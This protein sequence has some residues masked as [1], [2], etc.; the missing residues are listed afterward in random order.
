[1]GKAVAWFKHDGVVKS[2]GELLVHAGER[3]LAGGGRLT[4]G[5]RRLSDRRFI[6]AGQG[7]GGKYEKTGKKK[8][9]VAFHVIQMNH[10]AQKVV[11]LYLGRGAGKTPD[12]V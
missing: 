7:A 9:A 4:F 11:R 5:E 6:G 3:L 10:C 1:M 2:K 8:Q 12:P